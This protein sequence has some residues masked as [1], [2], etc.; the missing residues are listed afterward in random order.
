MTDANGDYSIAELPPGLYEV[1]ASMAGYITQT[2]ENIEV[3]AGQIT[4][5]D[6]TLPPEVQ[7]QVEIG[8]LIVYADL[9]VETSPSVY[10]VS[11]NVNINGVLHFSSDLTIDV[12]GLSI[13]GTAAISLRDIPYIGDLQIYEGEI[14][15][16]VVEDALLSVINDVADYFEVGG[17]EVNFT[18]LQLLLDGIRVAGEINFPDVIGGGIDIENLSISQSGGVEIVGEFCLPDIHINSMGLKDM[19]LSFDTINDIFGGSLTVSTPLVGIGGSLEF[20]QG[21]LNSIHLSVALGTQI[22]IGH[23]G[24]FLEGGSGGLDNLA[25]P[26]PVIITLV[27]DI[28]G[29]PDV[30]GVA[31]VRFDDVGLEIQ[32]PVYIIGTGGIQFFNHGVADGQLKYSRK[33][34][35]IQGSVALGDVYDSELKG[36]INSSRVNGQA[37]GR[38]HTPSDLPWWLRLAEDYTIGN[39]ESD[40]NNEKLRGKA[41]FPVSAFKKLRLAFILEFGNPNFPWFHFYLGTNYSNLRQIFRAGLIAQV[42]EDVMIPGGTQQALFYV[43]GTNNIAP[44]FELIMPDGTHITPDDTL[45]VRRDQDKQAFFIIGDPAAG[46]WQIYVPDPGGDDLRFEV[47]GLNNAPAIQII[48]PSENTTSGSI[49]WIDTDIDDDAEIELFYDDDNSGLNGEPITLTPISEDDETDQYVW[50]Y[51]EV[52]SGKYYIYAVISDTMNAPVYSYS[53][54]TIEV[55]DLEAP[56]RPQGLNGTATDTSIQLN[57]L[58]NS[59]DDLL[60]YA[61]HYTDDLSDPGY[62]YQW[63]PGDTT[64]C[65]IINM[66]TGRTYRLALVSF[67]TLGHESALSDSIFVNV[68]NST[69]NNPPHITS[70]DPPTNAIEGAEYTFELTAEDADL[71]PVNFSLS[72]FPSSMYII[73]DIIHW[74][75]DETHLGNNPVKVYADDGNEGVDSLSFIIHVSNAAESE[76]SIVLDRYEYDSYEE[77]GFVTVEDFDLNLDQSLIDSVAISLVSNS[78]PTGISIFCFENSPNTANFIGSFLLSPDASN[79]DLD[80]LLATNGD[81]IVAHYN[82]LNPPNTAED[83]AILI[84]GGNCVYLPGDCNHNGTPLELGDA[85]A[86]IGMYR[87]TVVP[88]YECPCPPHG[89]NFAPTADPNGNCVALELGDVVTEIAAYRGTGTATGC[90]DCPG[91]LRIGPRGRERLPVIPSLKS[92]MKIGKR[93]VL[94]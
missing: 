45:F 15:F 41:E 26:E 25:T 90:E 93:S 52:P 44:D 78:D 56:A 64:E 55:L 62:L 13:T 9:I 91:S 70:T 24:L 21:A 32:V 10:A 65:E 1:E 22:P 17:F 83:K 72:I 61:V 28:T 76:G 4:T 2:E 67:D 49:Q 50:D 27:I 59:D 75:P 58:P 71:D 51:S 74:T 23:T 35:E 60:G 48:E 57:W 19:C 54:G 16:D 94:E 18:E 5:V 80:Q 73:S 86:M 42:T 46:L 30:G 68:Q 8:N 92:K 40:I 36:H 12:L 7:N 20:T 87:G 85:I 11:G 37:S 81:T 69:A 14:S 63:S 84:L 43:G 82:D 31:I 38:L 39:A 88:P 66:P 89:D 77:V 79:D 29:G 6:F 34:L 53:G 33:G 3:I 47:Y